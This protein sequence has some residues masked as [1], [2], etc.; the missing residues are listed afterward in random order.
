M[1]MIAGESGHITSSFSCLEILVALYFGGILKHD[2]SNPAMPDRDRFILSKGH[3]AVG[4]YN[5]LCEAGFFTREELNTYCNPN[6]IF[7]GHPT[8]DIP[9]IECA[10]GALGHGL[11]FAVG[12]ALAA[13]LKKAGYLTYAVT[14]D[15]ECQEGSIWE[16]AMSIAH[17][18]LTNL[19]WIIDRNG[20]QLES[21]V[22]DIMELSPLDKKLQAF[23][24]NT[25]TINGHDFSELLATL[26]I[27]RG[28]PPEKP[29]AIIANTIKGR[30]VPFLENKLDWHGRKPT[31][32][33]YKIIVE[34]LNTPP[35]G[36]PSR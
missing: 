23:G 15:G 21:S 35:E 26:R 11:S 13:R 17:F 8:P 9:G 20:I 24:F 31:K 22:E 32:D 6:S 18:R 34:Q 5:V 16:A 10:T 2:S 27:D 1:G 7:G 4:I 29:L 19:I 12:L 30:G 33:E 28:N 14:G 3:G 36:G 25:V